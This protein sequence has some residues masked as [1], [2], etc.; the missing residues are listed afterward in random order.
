MDAVVENMKSP[1]EREKNA[2]IGF[3]LFWIAIAFFIT[4]I[5][6]LIFFG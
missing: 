5:L 6:L 3:R 4:G 1:E 2:R